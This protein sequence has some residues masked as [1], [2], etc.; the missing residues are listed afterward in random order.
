MVKTVWYELLGGEGASKA[1]AND[2][3]NERPC[4]GIFPDKDIAEEIAGFLWS[5]GSGNIEIIEV[6]A[7]W[8]RAVEKK[9]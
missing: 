9:N 4:F 2:G 1:V 6:E 7:D 8:A 5:V 3:V